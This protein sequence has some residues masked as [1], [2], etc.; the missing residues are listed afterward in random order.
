MSSRAYEAHVYAARAAVNGR[1][2]QRD[3]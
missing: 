2:V 1:D 3:E